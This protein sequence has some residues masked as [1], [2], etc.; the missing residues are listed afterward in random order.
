MMEQSADLL[1]APWFTSQDVKKLY[2]SNT[3]KQ[4]VLTS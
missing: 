3:A 2:I 1:D 4:E